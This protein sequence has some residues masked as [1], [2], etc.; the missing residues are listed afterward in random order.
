[1]SLSSIGW[2]HTCETM[3][4]YEGAC[5]S[6]SLFILQR[7]DRP[8]NIFPPRQETGCEALFYGWR[9]STFYPESPSLNV[10]RSCNE[11]WSSSNDWTEMVERKPLRGCAR[12]CSKRLARMERAISFQTRGIPKSMFS[13]KRA[14][15]PAD[16]LAVSIYINIY[17]L[18]F[19]GDFYSR[20]CCLAVCQDG[21]LKLLSCET[22]NRS[23]AISCLKQLCRTLRCPDQVEEKI[24]MHW[25]I[26]HHCWSLLSNHS[27]LFLFTLNP[28]NDISQFWIGW[29]TVSPQF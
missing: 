18:L 1:M 28:Q 13:Q 12:L 9:A 14:F 5:R 17:W 10:L 8:L 25:N 7:Q 26:S 20:P 22:W 21:S 23:H 4:W 15:Q 11:C 27:L 3:R 16:L 24:T 6:L 2:L 19:Q 29:Y